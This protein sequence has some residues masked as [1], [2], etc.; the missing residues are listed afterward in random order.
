MTTFD[1]TSI[2][3]KEILE[4]EKSSYNFIDVR[5]PSEIELQGKIKGFVNVPFQLM[6]TDLGLFRSIFLE[7][8]DKTVYRLT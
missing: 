3:L 2:K 7:Y 4:T 8:R 1:I 6:Q 5:E